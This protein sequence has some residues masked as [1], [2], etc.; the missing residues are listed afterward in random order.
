MSRC[1]VDGARGRSPGDGLCARRR[2]AA[3]VALVVAGATLLLAAGGCASTKW[4]SLRSSPR[5]PLSDTL[6][7]VTRTGPKPT[8]RTVQLLRRFDLAGQQA[9]KPALLAKLRS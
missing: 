4:V 1:C 8:P 6:G 2:R 3:L 9:D 7:L 5:N